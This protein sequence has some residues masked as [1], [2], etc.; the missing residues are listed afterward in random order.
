MWIK[1]LGAPV[2]VNTGNKCV[3]EFKPI[4]AQ[5]LS[6]LMSKS[7]LNI[8]K[9]WLQTVL[10]KPLKQLK[11]RLIYYRSATNLDLVNTVHKLT[12]VSARSQLSMCWLSVMNAG[13]NE[14]KVNFASQ[15]RA[16]VLNKELSVWH[17]LIST[18]GTIKELLKVAQNECQT[19]HKQ[20]SLL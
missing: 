2:N 3:T 8:R 12:F 19:T 6:M 20:D 14:V 15:K 7:S 10:M 9:H 18:P 16:F 5:C 4:N 1:R 17:S 13:L 11:A